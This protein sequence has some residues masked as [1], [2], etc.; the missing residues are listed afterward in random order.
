MNSSQTTHTMEECTRCKKEDELTNGLCFDCNLVLTVPENDIRLSQSSQSTDV[1]P[2]LCENGAMT[3]KSLMQCTNCER[4]YHP[5]CVGLAGL[6]KCTTKTIVGWKCPVCFVFP[7]A[8]AEK[9]KADI[10]VFNDEPAVTNSSMHIQEE[11]RKGVLAALPDIVSGVGGV[12]EGIVSNSNE[13]IGLS[14]AEV[15]KVDQ[16]KVI[17][18]VV[19]ETSKSA[20]QKSIQLIDS[21]LA[22]QKKREKNAVMSGLAE[23]TGAG[24]STLKE[25]VADFLG[26]DCSVNDLVS[27]KRLGEKKPRGKRLIL[28]V[29]KNEEAARHFHNYGRGREV[30]DKVW[31]N[32]DLTRTE[33]DA[34]YAQRQERKEKRKNRPPVRGDPQRDTDNN[35]P[36]GTEGVNAER[37]ASSAPARREEPPAPVVHEPPPAAIP[38][39]N[40][41]QDTAVQPQSNRD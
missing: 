32:P 23:D 37:E 6:T 8:M 17:K 26:Y 39:N 31:V 10:N 24:D 21:N 27:V 36:V 19:E 28:I 16:K 12:V 3:Y 35:R 41:D 25:V 5:A 38:A 30:S 20:L 1:T 2:C 11:V 15:V 7:R 40:H 22:E 14:F 4:W 29:F 9:I 34:M 18:E 33:R 13:K